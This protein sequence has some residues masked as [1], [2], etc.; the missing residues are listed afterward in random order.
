L[1]KVG[2]SISFLHSLLRLSGL[3]RIP[4]VGS[5]HRPPFRYQHMTVVT[6]YPLHFSTL[7]TAPYVAPPEQAPCSRV[8]SWQCPPR[9]ESPPPPAVACPQRSD[10]R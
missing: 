3:R 7:S 10:S 6:H 4:S 5:R 1:L 8:T 2:V 9:T